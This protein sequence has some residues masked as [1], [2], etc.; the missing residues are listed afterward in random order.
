MAKATWHMAT[1]QHGNSQALQRRNGNKAM[2]TLRWQ[3]GNGNIT[4]ATWQW[5]HDN[6]YMAMAT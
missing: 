5:T 3:H 2:T 4:M 6:R 1:W